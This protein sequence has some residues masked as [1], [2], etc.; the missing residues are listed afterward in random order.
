MDAGGFGATLGRMQ[1][2]SQLIVWQR[3]QALTVAVYRATNGFATSDAVGFRSQLRRSTASIGANIAEG[4]GQAGPTQFARFLQMAIASTSEVESHLDLAQRL[5]L[6]K[7]S[8]VSHLKSETQ[9]LRRMLTVLR[10]RVQEGRE[11]KSAAE[12]APPAADSQPPTEHPLN[13]DHPN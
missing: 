13:T 10:R 12:E 9:S 7:P 8:L 11:D 2:F 1:D 5:G 3:A 4:A 6:F